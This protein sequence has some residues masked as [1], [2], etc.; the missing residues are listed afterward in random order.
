MTG[1]TIGKMV[2]KLLDSEVTAPL[3]IVALDVAS[4]ALK[5]IDEYG[6]PFGLYASISHNLVNM[7]IDVKNYAEQKSC[8]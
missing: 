5:K 6:R 3:T 1:M 4:I 7:Y 8:F 2:V